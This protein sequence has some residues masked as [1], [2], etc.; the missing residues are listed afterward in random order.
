MG[1]FAKKRIPDHEMALIAEGA[2]KMTPPEQ[3]RLA[4]RLVEHDAVDQ[5]IV[6]VEI[7]IE[8]L[9]RLR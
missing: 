5:A 7:A 8:S 3:L 2:L 9:R 4:A 1:F 6:I